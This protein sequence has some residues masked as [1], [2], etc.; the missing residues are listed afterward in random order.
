MEL[1]RRLAAIP[2]IDNIFVVPNDRR[3]RP[4]DVEADVRWLVPPRNLGFGGGFRYACRRL[5]ATD[6]YLLLNNDIQME[7]ATVDA[8][9]DLLAQPRVGIVS[10]AGQ[11]VAGRSVAAAER[12]D[13]AAALND[14]ESEVACDLEELVSRDRSP[15]ERRVM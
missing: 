13:H 9:L 5:P 10:A 14:P 11:V 3:E 4:N 2:R 6:C 7:A 8:C 12:H 15:S 1:T